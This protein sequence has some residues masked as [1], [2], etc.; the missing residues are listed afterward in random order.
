[1]EGGLGLFF[2][3]VP[4]RGPAGGSSLYIEVGA[5]GVPGW[6]LSLP[7]TKS[8]WPFSGS[9]RGRDPVLDLRQQLLPRGDPSR[10][11]FEVTR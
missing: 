10:V 11:L 8:F 7:D 2:W 1:M 9:A 4:P 3:L 5:R 6:Y